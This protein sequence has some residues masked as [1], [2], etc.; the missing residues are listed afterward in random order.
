MTSS[1]TS[2]ASAHPAPP[3]PPQRMQAWIGTP[4][5][6]D[7][8][9]VDLPGPAPD[10]ALVRVAAFSVNRGELN[11]FRRR[12]EGWRPGQDLAGVVLRAAADGSGPAAG[13]VASSSWGRPCIH[14]REL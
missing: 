14:I 4:D 5:G 2:P 10:E 6:P 9:T 13:T 11:L 1:L 7:L 12:A 8:R 3:V